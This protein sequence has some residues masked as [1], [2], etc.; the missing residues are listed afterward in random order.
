MRD[1]GIARV[2]ATCCTFPFTFRITR[3]PS[4]SRTSAW[5]VVAYAAAISIRIVSFFMVSG[6]ICVVVS[7]VVNG[8]LVPLWP[9]VE[10]CIDHLTIFLIFSR[11]PERCKN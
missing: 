6:G 7:V 2:V 1:C 4:L 10:T 11:F 5:D 9:R 8:G 3:M